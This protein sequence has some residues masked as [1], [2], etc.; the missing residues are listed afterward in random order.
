VTPVRGRKEAVVSSAQDQFTSSSAKV[1]L[2]RSRR[3]YRSAME[4]VM[5]AEAQAI[6]TDDL[7]VRAVWERLADQI[8]GRLAARTRTVA[9]WPRA[10]SR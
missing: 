9:Q 8:A 7:L 1:N 3:S 4:A 10:W 6:A 5:R 2:P